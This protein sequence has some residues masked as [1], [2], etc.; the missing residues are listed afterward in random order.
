MSDILDLT[1]LSG[2]VLEAARDIRLLRLQMDNLA[3][4][5]GALE[6]R[7]SMLDQRLASVEQSIHDVIGEMSRG[8]GQMQQHLTRHEK[9]FDAVDAGLAALRETATENTRQLGEIIGLLSR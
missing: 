6:Q 3:S 4:R 9:R 1:L 2:T 5:L 8:F 7:F